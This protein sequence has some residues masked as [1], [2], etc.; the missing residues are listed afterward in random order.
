MFLNYYKVCWYAH[1]VC[2]GLGHLLHLPLTYW[3]GQ[4]GKYMQRRRHGKT[5][6]N[7]L[8]HSSQRSIL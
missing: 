4:Q 7:S 1:N 2:M 5:G 6:R 3:K 8:P